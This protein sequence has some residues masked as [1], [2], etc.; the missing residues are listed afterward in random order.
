MCHFP[1]DHTTGHGESY[2]LSRVVLP[3]YRGP[4]RNI[5]RLR[6]IESAS[7]CGLGQYFRI[8]LLLFTRFS[9]LPMFRLHM[10]APSV[11]KAARVRRVIDFS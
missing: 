8:A 3:V 7:C 9:A 4:N 10:E 2:P 6:L 1:E 5:E 11:V